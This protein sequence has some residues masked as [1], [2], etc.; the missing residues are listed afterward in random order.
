MLVKE[1][2]NTNKNKQISR[3]YVLKFAIYAGALLGVGGRGGLG[4]VEINLRLNL[5]L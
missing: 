5:P 2:K 1:E 4:M 3:T